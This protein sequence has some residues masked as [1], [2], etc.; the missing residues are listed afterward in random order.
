[1]QQRLNETISRVL[2]N[3]QDKIFVTESADGKPKEL[4]L[5]FNRELVKRA[6]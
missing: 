4:R 6:P 5:L 2:T 3:V 1:V